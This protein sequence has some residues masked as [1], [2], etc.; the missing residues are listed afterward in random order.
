MITLKT[1]W[2]LENVY[3]RS[4]FTNQIN[5]HHFCTQLTYQ[6]STFS[7]ELLIFFDCLDEDKSKTV[8]NNHNR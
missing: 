4:N 7:F 6:Q 2:E 3:L 8:N 1:S 5:I